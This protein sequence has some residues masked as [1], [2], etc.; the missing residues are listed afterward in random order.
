MPKNGNFGDIIEYSGNQNLPAAEY[1]DAIPD[2]DDEEINIRDYIDVV[3]RRKWLLLFVL[4][5]VFTTSLISTLSQNKIYRASGTLQVS[6]TTQKVTKFDDVV[7]ENLNSKAYISTQVA[8]LKSDV[9]AARAL[10][11]LDIA[12]YLKQSEKKKNGKIFQQVKSFIKSLLPF[13]T[14]NAAENP[15]NKISK[16]IDEKKYIGFFKNHLSVSTQKN[17]TMISISF[18]STSREF[19]RNAVNVVMEEFVDW[20][21]DQKLKS[22]RKAR[23]YLMKQIE[24]AKIN[25]ENAE[26]QQNKF[27]RQAG[28]V[29]M[30]SRLNSVF[31]QLEDINNALSEAETALIQKKAR[32]EQ[33]MKGGRE[34]LPKVL[35]S[36]LIGNLKSQYA[37]LQSEYDHLEETFH[38]EY[39]DVKQIRSRMRSLEERIQNEIQVIIDSI[40]NEYLAAQSR[41]E[42]LK[43]KMEERKQEAL[44][45]NQRATQYKI[46]ER[47]VETN[48]AI[49]Q[50]L[51]ER[52]KEIESM[53]GVSPTNIQVVDKASLPIFPAKPDVK[54][55]L[56]LAIVLGL[57]GG[58]GAAF[59]MEYFADTI[60]NPDQI[61]D[62]FQLPILGVIPLVKESN[63]YPVEKTFI[64][65]PRSAMSEAFRT[66]KVSIQLSGS[67][68]NARCIAITSTAPGEG[69]T[70]IAA[71]MAQTFAGAG[72]KVVLIDADLRK[73]RL[74]KVFQKAS[75][76]NDGNG[77]S[78]FLAGVINNRF[79]AKTSVDNLYLIPSGPIPPNPVELLAS[80]RFSMLLKKLSERF[81]RIILD[82]PPHQGFADVLVLSR[83]VGGLILVSSI[84]E[85]TRDGLRHF[86]K[87]MQNV[88]GNILGCVVNKVNLDQRYG[89]RSYYKYYRAYYYDYGDQ[90]EKK[91]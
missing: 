30:D 16:A 65:N 52:A 39:P 31:K 46:M 11:N 18:G 9:V 56:L 51:L 74:N 44:A 21:M 10:E 83:K 90:K 61:T 47:E 91:T 68:A 50:S 34:S 73:P 12:S 81:D 43:E 26:E 59:V 67:D 22:S 4:L 1:R 80:N 2:Y 36:E 41:V 19:S 86:K 45:L 63:E 5:V 32:Y 54:R 13:G 33:A 78:S 64:N 72:E 27:A 75:V 76:A 14:T 85:T 24:Q 70:T 66:S 6:P 62:R 57:I 88:Q 29:S 55:N 8:L 60:T 37:E 15:E 42:A 25:L 23:E 87:G 89:Y 49:Y 82:A 3:F 38:A 77:L 53:A 7:E 28:I 79:I 20:K 35:E 17:S 58:I 71:N 48:K 84:G 40:E 69:K